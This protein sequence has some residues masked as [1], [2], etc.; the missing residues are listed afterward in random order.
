[1]WGF[2]LYD[3][4]D[5]DAAGVVF[6]DNANRLAPSLGG[7]VPANVRALPHHDFAVPRLPAV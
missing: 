4:A 2:L 3:D 6:K 5:R 1:M 7:S